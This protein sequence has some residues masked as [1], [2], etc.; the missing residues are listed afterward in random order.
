MSN[1]ERHTI[2]APVLRHAKAL[3]QPSVLVRLCEQPRRIHEIFASIDQVTLDD[4]RVYKRSSRA[5]RKY[6]AIS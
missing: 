5:Y 4:S 2:F 6:F 1:K 3:V